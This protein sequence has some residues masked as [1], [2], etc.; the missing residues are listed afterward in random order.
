MTQ[1]T[2]GNWKDRADNYIILLSPLSPLLLQGQIRYT[3]SNIP[4]SPKQHP[5]LLI[6]TFPLPS[7][8]SNRKYPITTPF[9]DPKFSTSKT[10]NPLHLSCK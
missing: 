10:E 4:P 6:P 8:T 1:S 2:Y 7:K 5:H 3:K 9:T